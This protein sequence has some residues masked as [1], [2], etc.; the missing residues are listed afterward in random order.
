MGR[1]INFRGG[2]IQLEI[3]SSNA[4]LRVKSDQ[5]TTIS[6]ILYK[7]FS[8]PKLLGKLNLTIDGLL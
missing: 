3:G 1:H 6:Y 8:S 7:S 4:F 5:R 2:L